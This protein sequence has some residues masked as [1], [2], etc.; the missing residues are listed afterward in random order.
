MALGLHSIPH[1]FIR[2]TTLLGYA[3]VALELE[4]VDAAGALLPEIVALAPEVSFNGVTSQGPIAAYADKLLSLLGRYDEGAPH[5][6]DALAV[7]EAFGWEYHRASTLIA[8]AHNHAAP[9]APSTVPPQRGSEKR[10]VSA[11]SMG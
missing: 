1:D 6:I 11:A 5:R 8:L 10:M 3:I 7:A 4:D 9:P 2:S